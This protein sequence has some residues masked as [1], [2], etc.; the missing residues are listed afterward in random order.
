MVVVQQPLAE[1]NDIF[2]VCIVVEH[3]PPPCT[4]KLHK[5][6]THQQ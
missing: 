5:A 6:Y 3:P 2:T 1:C 4:V